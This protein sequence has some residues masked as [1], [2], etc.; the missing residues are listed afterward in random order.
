MEITNKTLEVKIVTTAKDKWIT[1][2][3][4]VPATERIFSDQLY[5]GVNDS[6]NNWKEVTDAYK[7]SIEKEAKGLMPK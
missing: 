3:A 6:E 4:D 1:Q 7:T 2:A 5:L